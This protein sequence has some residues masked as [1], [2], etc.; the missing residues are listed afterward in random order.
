[1]M[2]IYTAVG[3]AIAAT[4]VNSSGGFEIRIYRIGLALAGYP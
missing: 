4:D 1:M 3:G 2:E